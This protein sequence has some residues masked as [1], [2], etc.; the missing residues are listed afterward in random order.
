[1]LI[2]AVLQ[3]DSVFIFQNMK[4]IHIL[5]HI[6]FHNVLPLDIEQFPV[7]FSRTLLFI[8]PSCN[9]LHL[10]IPNPQSILPFPH[11]DNPKSVLYICESASVS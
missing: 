7:P 8:Q 4:K 1:M 3:S 9:S 6:L 11:A 5:F 10:M 2:S